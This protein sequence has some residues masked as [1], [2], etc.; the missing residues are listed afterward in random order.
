VRSGSDRRCHFFGQCPPPNNN[1]EAAIRE[2]TSTHD[3]INSLREMR[4]GSD[5]RC[6]FG[7]SCRWNLLVA[8][9]AVPATRAAADPALSRSDLKKRKMSR[10][11]GAL[12]AYV[13]RLSSFQEAKRRNASSKL[14]QVAE[15][16]YTHSADLVTARHLQLEVSSLCSCT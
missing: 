15:S 4:S 1:T 6:H 2:D 5:R 12:C 9:G 3:G 14:A 11:K 7:L 13:I 10:V 8:V 16:K